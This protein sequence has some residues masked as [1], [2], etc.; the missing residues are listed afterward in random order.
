MEFKAE[1]RSYLGRYFGSLWIAIV[2]LL[3]LYF[4]MKSQG[5]DFSFFFSIFHSNNLKGT[6]IF[7]IIPVGNHI[8]SYLTT[9]KYP[10][11]LKLSDNLITI[12]FFRKTSLTLKYSEIK[13]LEYSDKIYRD[14]VFILKNGEK[15]VIPSA[16]RSYEKAFEE[17][18]K[19]I[20]ENN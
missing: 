9:N 10:K 16:V 15:K 6:L 4:R 1:Y 5:Y 7:L 12:D 18:N 20:K 11:I 19:K 14:F 13:S 8:I 2:I 17:I 3:A